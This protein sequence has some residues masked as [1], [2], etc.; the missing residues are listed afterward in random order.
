[1]HRIMGLLLVAVAVGCDRTPDPSSSATSTSPSTQASSSAAA[2]NMPP[3]PQGHGMMAPPAA[4]EGPP[5][6]SWTDPPAWKRSAPANAMRK[7]EYAVPHVGKDTEDAE[8][9]VYNFGAGQGGAVQANLDRWKQQMVAVA[10]GEPKTTTSTVS[11]MNVTTLEMAGTSKPSA[12]MGAP[13][14]A[15]TNQRM[16]GVVVE[17]QGGPWFFKLTGPDATVKDAAPAF[18]TMI[19]SIKKKG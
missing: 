16:I 7:A 5:A 19:E 17:A 12:M 9:V 10:G 13:G 4:D 3:L 14:P 18:K 2:V 8:C 6:I 15:K 1:M 11:G